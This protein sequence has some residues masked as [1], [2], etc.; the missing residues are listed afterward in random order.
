MTAD[1]WNDTYNVGQ[2]V[3]YHPVIGE[4]AFIQT[5]TRE[6]AWVTDSGHHVTM[7]KGKSGYVSLEA[8]SL[9]RPLCFD[10]GAKPVDTCPLCNKSFCETCCDK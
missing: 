2:I 9:P 6:P 3:H 5:E 10:C 4:A 7:V 8:L 1:Q